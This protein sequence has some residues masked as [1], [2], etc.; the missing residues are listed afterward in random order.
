[1]MNRSGPT[2]GQKE[3]TLIR[4]SMETVLEE[5]AVK[6]KENCQMSSRNSGHG[7]LVVPSVDFCLLSGQ[8]LTV[9]SHLAPVSKHGIQEYEKDVNTE[10]VY[11]RTC[12]WEFCFHPRALQRDFLVYH[13]LCRKPATSGE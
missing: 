13:E 4:K 5:V 12:R 2:D 6:K 1:M 9:T 7:K 11:A 8:R 10:K 3:Y